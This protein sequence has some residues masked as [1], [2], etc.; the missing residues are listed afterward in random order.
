MELN[1]TTLGEKMVRLLRR[2][3]MVGAGAV[4]AVATFGP[5]RTRAEN[6]G[7]PSL[8][9]PAEVRA[10]AGGSVVL[11]AQPGTMRF[12]SGPAKRTYG[13]NGPYLGPAVRLRRGQRVIAQVQNRVPQPITMH[14][15]GL[16][17]PGAADGGPHQ[18][19]SLR[20]EDTT[21]MIRTAGNRP[22]CPSQCCTIRGISMLVAALSL[23]GRIP[24]PL[25]RKAWVG[26][27]T[28]LGLDHEC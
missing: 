10:N 25:G 26:A 8:P 4:C 18:A 11:N 20:H 27:C 6:G 5:A 16:I 12:R 17:I 3:L 15:H 1:T 28:E 13:I 2:T 14:W 19:R 21:I 9:I 23:T 24:R 7:R 22:T